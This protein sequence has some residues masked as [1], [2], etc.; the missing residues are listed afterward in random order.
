M[1]SKINI[2]VIGCGIAANILHWPA[3]KS[4]HDNF[5]I[6]AV[7]NH[8]EEKASQF[9]KLVGEEYS[10]DIPTYLDYKQLL[11]LDSVDAVAV[12]LPIEFNYEVCKAA[13]KAG[14]HIMVEK[15]IA[16]NLE[17]AKLLLEL[18]KKF[19]D[20]V[21]MVAE[22]FRYRPVYTAL[23]K[24]IQDK[25]IGKPYYVEWKNWANVNP[26]DNQYAKTSWRI[27]HQ[28]EGGFVTDGGVHNIAALRDI[29]GDLE[30]TGSSKVQVNPEIGRTDTL[31]YLFKSKGRDGIPPVSGLLQM[32]FSVKRKTSQSLIVLGSNGSLEVEDDTMT[33]FEGNDNFSITSEKFPDD[34]GYENE[35]IDFYSAISRNTAIK[36]SF[37][38]AYCDFET[39]MHALK[40]AKQLENPF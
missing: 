31:S 4:L 9:A 22:N 39:I 29:F 16:V 3:I 7:C 17:E 12:I 28:Y 5:T 30:L 19:P 21:M 11:A 27:N 36:S 32:F 38:E 35:Y 2:G 37:F 24:T 13:A 23:K 18:E 33:I 20:L 8:T 6:T 25:L 40:Q 14:K 26:K 1:E 10:K 15:P 34:G